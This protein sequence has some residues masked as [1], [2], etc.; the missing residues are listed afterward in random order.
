MSREIKVLF[1]HA[2]KTSVYPDSKVIKNLEFV[3]N[4]QFLF[5]LS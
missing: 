2:I 5:T 4:I 1:M 3:N